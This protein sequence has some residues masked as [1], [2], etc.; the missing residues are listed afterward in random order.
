MKFA[1]KYETLQ[2]VAIGRVET[3][4]ARDRANNHKVIVHTFECPEQAIGQSTIECNLAAF[5]VLAASPAASVIDAG[6]FDG[7]F[8]GYLVTEWPGDE[9]LQEWVRCYQ[10]KPQHARIRSRWGNSTPMFGSGQT[11]APA[12]PKANLSGGPEF[13]AAADGESSPT[14]MFPAASGGPPR[15]AEAKPSDKV[16]ATSGGISS[17]FQQRGDMAPKPAGDASFRVPGDFTNQF[18]LG[19]HAGPV[20]PAEPTAEETNSLGGNRQPAAVAGDETLFTS[21]LSLRQSSPASSTSST[22]RTG[23]ALPKVSGPLLKAIEA[24]R[25]TNLFFKP[26]EPEEPIS[27]QHFEERNLGGTAEAGEFTSFFQGPFSGEKPVDVPKI[28]LDATPREKIPSDFTRVFGSSEKLG[29]AEPQMAPIPPTSVVPSL[30]HGSFTELF[31]SPKP[32]APKEPVES[33][34]PPR[35]PAEPASREVPLE[36]DRQ[37]PS[38]GHSPGGSPEPVVEPKPFSSNSVRDVEDLNSLSGEGGNATRVFSRP[39]GGPSM[40]QPS[41][42]SGPSAWTIFQRS[43]KAAP[44]PAEAPPVPPASQSPGWGGLSPE[45]PSPATPAIPSAP[46]PA[47]PYVAPPQVPYTVPQPAMPAPAVPSPQVPAAPLPASPQVSYSIPQPAI[48]APPA[49]APPSQQPAPTPKEKVSYWPLLIVLNVL[50]IIAVLL[51]LYFALKH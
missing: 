24:G 5:S 41:V 31:A 42:P 26:I 21:E 3:F 43:E 39:S 9:A 30:P 13:G 51:I 48:P 16:S 4:I 37:M 14:L 17:F 19:S 2:K 10:G 34:W 29:S 12:A 38:V 36:R 20:S 44:I 1:A 25:F 33:N 50:F 27:H 45:I 49:V 47:A 23:E 40:D 32:T 11:I 18:F 28:S 6:R 22:E 7:T 15:P 35:Q 46:V 8:F